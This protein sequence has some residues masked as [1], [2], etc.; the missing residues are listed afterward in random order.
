MPTAAIEDMKG[1]SIMDIAEVRSQATSQGNNAVV[2]TRVFDAPREAV[3]R[4]WTNPELMAQ[5]YAPEPL[6]VPKSEMDLRV[7]GRY[8]LVMRDEDGNDFTST[9]V[10]REIMAPERLSYTDS[11]EEMPQD[12]VDMVNEARGQEKGTPIP[13]SIVTIIFEDVG[14]K[15][16][17]TFRDDFDS[18]TTR[19]AF[20]EM[21]M[22]EGLEASFDNLEKVLAKQPSMTL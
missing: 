3:F 8:R 9:G 16:K 14:G 18:A 21:Q 22:V 20:V 17:V 2:V 12:W 6:T 19:D 4:A 11:L 1:R 7:G 15:T 10:Y 5:W 13:D